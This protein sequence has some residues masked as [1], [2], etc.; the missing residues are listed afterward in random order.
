MKFRPLGARCSLA[1]QPGQGRSCQSQ[2]SRDQEGKPIGQQPPLSRHKVEQIRAE[3][4]KGTGILKTACCAG[5]GIC[6]AADQSDDEA[7]GL[8][9][10]EFGFR[11]SAAR[12]GI[13]RHKNRRSAHLVTHAGY[14]HRRSHDLVACQVTLESTTEVAVA[15]IGPQRPVQR[16]TLFSM[17]Y[18]RVLVTNLRHSLDI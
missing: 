12:R 9:P 6:G 2:A 4:Q 7:D 1:T 10:T 18:A 8:I 3:L 15:H 5:P 17:K 16:T 14:N 11:L 13:L